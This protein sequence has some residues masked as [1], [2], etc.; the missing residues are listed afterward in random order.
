MG[1]DYDDDE[2]S[3]ESFRIV[4]RPAMGSGSDTSDD[5][6]F[7]PESFCIV[8]RKKPRPDTDQQGAAD[9]VSVY[10]PTMAALSP[11]PPS[12]PRSESGA[13]RRRRAPRPHCTVESIFSN[14]KKRRGALIR[15][16]TKGSER[17]SISLL[18]YVHMSRLYSSS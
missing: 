11:F 9:A 16:L 14:F 3:A 10:V 18:S 13:R 15:A 4:R 17:E 2:F 7:S 8:R 6:E 5:D 1:S 12:S